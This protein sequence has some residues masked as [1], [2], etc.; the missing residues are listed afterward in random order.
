M[1][2]VCTRVALY[3][4]PMLVICVA[5]FLHFGHTA[6]T[7]PSLS[8][9]VQVAGSESM[10]PTIAAIAEDFMMRNPLA[11]ITV[12]GGGSGDGIAALL[13]GMIDIAMTSREVTLRE[14]AYVVDK[15]LELSIVPLALDAV[16]I[17]INQANPITVLDFEQIRNIF[18]GRIRNWSELQ[19]TE[20]EIVPL[21]RAA[22]SGTAYLFAERVLSADSFAGSVS[23]LPTNEAIVAQVAAR[24]GAIGYTGLGALRGANERVRTIALRSNQRSPP[25][26]ATADSI[27]SGSYPLSRKLSLATTG[28]LVATAKAFVDFCLSATG[29]TLFERAGYTEIQSAA[30]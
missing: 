13:H 6:E 21:A 10:R 23:H 16:V 26:M 1:L 17:V 18:A 28:H 20:T 11:D 22:G 5:L 2:W 14:R 25:M 9:L 4:L 30:R 8:E 12:K 3:N 19:G 24:P 7:P 27:L 29:R 15:G